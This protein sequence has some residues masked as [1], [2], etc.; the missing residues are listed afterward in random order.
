MG[1]GVSSKDSAVLDTQVQNLNQRI[2]SA[3]QRVTKVE[4]LLGDSRL[5]QNYSE[6]AR[7]IESE[8]S[9]RLNDL[10]NLIEETKHLEESH[11]FTPSE[12]AFEDSVRNSLK[13]KHGASILEDPSI[14]Y[15][16]EKNRQKL[17]N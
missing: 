13:E 8:L 16:L 3:D 9:N 12:P 11:D 2:L 14:K 5:T 1:C 6:A 10:E 4:G 17:K 15:L 7:K